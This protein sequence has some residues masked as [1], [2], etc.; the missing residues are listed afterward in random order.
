[1]VVTLLLKKILYWT[2]VSI[3]LDVGWIL[4]LNEKKTGK[5]NPNGRD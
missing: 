3:Q 5:I 2:M 1:M 4:N